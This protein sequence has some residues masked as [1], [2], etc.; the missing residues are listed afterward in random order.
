MRILLVEDSE[1]VQRA[2]LRLVR[3][4]HPHAVTDVVDAAPEAIERLDSFAYDYVLSD[5]DLRIGTGGD[6]LRHVRAHLPRYVD[7]NRF[8]LMS[9]DLRPCIHALG[10]PLTFEKPLDPSRFRTLLTEGLEHARCAADCP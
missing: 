5:F 4:V 2:I 7:Q 8:L 1:L 9:G 3:S 6:V 10:H